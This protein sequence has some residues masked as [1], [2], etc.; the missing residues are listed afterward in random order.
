MIIVEACCV[1]FLSIISLCR[2]RSDLS[3][4]EELGLSCQMTARVEEKQWARMMEE[5][6]NGKGLKGMDVKITVVFLENAA[7]RTV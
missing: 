1:P 5:V 3:S 4:I 2:G 6:E 7:V